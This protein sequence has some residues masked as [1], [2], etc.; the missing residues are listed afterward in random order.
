M[1]VR[2][3]VR[4]KGSPTSVTASIC[5]VWDVS[6]LALSV[7][8]CAHVHAQGAAVH[9]VHITR[10]TGLISVELCVA[11]DGHGTMLEKYLMIN[12]HSVK[13]VCIASAFE[14]SDSVLVWRRVWHS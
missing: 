5:S 8:E 2:G 7:S 10:S 4:R 3:T 14:S 11:L 13:M 9:R 12:I 1:G 6:C